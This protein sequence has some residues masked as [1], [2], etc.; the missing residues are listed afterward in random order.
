MSVPKTVIVDPA[1]ILD[2]A[3]WTMYESPPVLKFVEDIRERYSTGPDV[4]G[5]PHD[6]I[7]FEIFEE[8]R[9]LLTRNFFGEVFVDE[10]FEKAGFLTASNLPNWIADMANCL[11]KFAVRG[12]MTRTLTAE[13]VDAQ[14]AYISEMVRPKRGRTK[15]LEMRAFIRDGISRGLDD[16]EMALE[17]WD[18]HPDEYPGVTD[19]VAL[20]R[21]TWRIKKKRNSL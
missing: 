4:G 10:V 11:A 14:L 1:A 12:E 20:Q 8:S 6:Q 18:Q 5:Q 9:A 2:E 16:K 21:V 17:W 13:D 15:A 7:I 19:A 3:V